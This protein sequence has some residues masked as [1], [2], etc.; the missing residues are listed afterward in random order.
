MNT[1]NQSGPDVIYIGMRM[2]IA[3]AVGAAVV[4]LSAGCQN[5]TTPAAAPSSAASVSPQT[6]TP[7]PSAQEKWSGTVF[8]Y[9]VGEDNH[10]DVYALD[11][12]NRKLV[13]STPAGKDS[14]AFNSVSVSPDGRMIAWVNTGRE[15]L[16]GDLFLGTL[17]GAPAKKVA[18]G[19]VCGG[20]GAVWAPD[21]RALLVNKRTGNQV[22]DGRIDAA[23]GVFT[24]GKDP[25]RIW[26]PGGAFVARTDLDKGTI[27]IAKADGSVVRTVT[28][29]PTWAECEGW[30]AQT[31]SADGR[32][33][34]VGYAACDPSRLLSV[35]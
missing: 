1:G 15:R 35:D 22:A 4:A 30:R 7:A 12:A 2:M 11:G 17:G 20:T 23:T 26:S 9:R 13:A 3:T 25:G 8:A 27:T 33:L 28:Y 5:P 24:A 29:K 14:C 16:D 18:A 32:Y 34:S 6:P 31:L 21:S 19:I 10:V